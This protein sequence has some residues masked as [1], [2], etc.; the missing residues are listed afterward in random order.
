MTSFLPSSLSLRLEIAKVITAM[1]PVYFRS[2]T[3]AVQVD[4]VDCHELLE[5]LCH[6][7]NMLAEHGGLLIRSRN[8]LQGL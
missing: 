7:L 8:H 4:E 1:S 3:V 6:T 5:L 2:I